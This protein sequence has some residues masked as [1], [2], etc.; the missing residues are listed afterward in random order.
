MQTGMNAAEPE[1]KQAWKLPEPELSGRRIY[2]AGGYV[3]L[4]V[5][6]GGRPGTDTAELQKDLLRAYIAGQED[7]E[8][9]EIYCDNGR[10]GTDFERP[11]FAR[12][13]EDVRHGRID[14]IVVKDL[15]RFGRNY[16]DAGNYLERIFPLL[17]VRFV[18]VAD[19]FDTDGRRDAA[20]GYLV[21]LQ[22]IIN[23]AYSR[24]LSE[25]VGSAYRVRQRNG[26]FT[27][28]WASYGYR[29]CAADPHRIEPDEKAAPVVRAIFRWRLS[30]MGCTQIARELNRRD[31]ASPSR[32][33]YLRGDAKCERYAHAEWS[34]ATVRRILSSEVYLGHMVQGRK[35]QSFRE[36]IRQKRL[37]EA[38][39]TVVRN[40]HEPLIDEETFLAVQ[41]AGREACG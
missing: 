26:E 23:E 9:R 14:C 8:L 2:R 11:E 10:T 6:D 30:G 34:A 16:L 40:C 17:G 20:D 1:G 22:N 13:M 31:I 15:S 19:H 3:R 38:E 25:K 12:L 36:G 21:P 33:H 37:P 27:G 18:A 28:T 35:R 7:M 39:W 29:R 5:E 41:K 32:Y 24:D 4:S